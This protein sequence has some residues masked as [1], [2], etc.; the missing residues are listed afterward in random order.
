[1]IPNM[2]SVIAGFSTTAQFAVV[3]KAAVDFQSQE[4]LVETKW[5]GGVFQPLPERQL[6]IKP[7][8]ERTWMW[9]TLVCKEN[10]LL[11]W[12]VK[13]QCGKEYRVMSRSDWHH[14]GFYEYQLVEKPES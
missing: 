3:S 7:E 9:W 5:F 13:D 12:I 8:G 1:M 2:K 14:A 6:L 11:D 4:T 10:L